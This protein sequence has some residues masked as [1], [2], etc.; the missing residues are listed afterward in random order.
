M[1]KRRKVGNL[2][3]LAVLATVVQRPM[4]PYEMASLIRTRGKDQSMKIKWG[5]LYTVVQNLDKHGFIAPTETVRD[6]GRPERTVYAI[7]DA[8]RA[9]L[10]DWTRELVQTPG[11][12]LLTFEA[13]LSVL[14]AL[15][16]DEIAPLLRHRHDLLQQDIEARRERLPTDLPRLFLLEEEYGLAMREA[17][18]AWTARLLAEFDAGTFPGL[19]EWR[20]FHQTGQLS[21]DLAELSER[22]STTD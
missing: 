12:E 2:M 6:G 16:P 3:A 11:E 7:T 19:A 21:Q 17:E 20:A 15:P 14:A 18:R 4:H 9:E 10:R 13:A 5:S 1:A 8:G 22:G